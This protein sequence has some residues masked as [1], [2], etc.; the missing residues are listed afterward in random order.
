MKA[1]FYTVQK[2]YFCE[3][4]VGIPAEME[5]RCTECSGMVFICNECHSAPGFKWHE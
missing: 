4:N 1:K 5:S 2:C 3:S